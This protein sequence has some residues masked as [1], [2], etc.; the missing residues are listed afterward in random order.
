MTKPTY[1]QDYKA[2]EQVLLNEYSEGT[3][4]ANSA[5]MQP[6][7]DEV[8]TMY[9]VNGEGKLVGGNV[10][11]SLF[12]A[13]DKDFKPSE[14]PIIAIAYIDI[15]GTAAAARVDTD[16]MNGFGFTDYFNLL[17]INGKWKIVS[18]IFHGHY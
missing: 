14:N 5:I 2:I 6:A 18:K 3:K 9:S 15:V 13:I 12:P 16:N 10:R 17:K 7:F 1:T 4:Q 11:E 8:A